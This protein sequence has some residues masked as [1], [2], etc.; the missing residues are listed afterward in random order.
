MNITDLVE[1]EHGTR[2]WV[3]ARR[4][5]RIIERYGD[6]VVCLSQKQYTLLERLADVSCMREH[7]AL[8]IVAEMLGD[9]E[10]VMLLQGLRMRGWAVER[11]ER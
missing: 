7:P 9:K 1:R 5:K 10:A 4:T 6:G 11:C 2:N 8:P 3:V